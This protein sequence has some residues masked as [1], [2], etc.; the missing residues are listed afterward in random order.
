MRKWT[1]LTIGSVGFTACLLTFVA[2]AKEQTAIRLL[3]GALIQAPSIMFDTQTKAWL[4]THPTINVAYLDSPLQP[5]HLGVD[6]DN[7]EGVTANY[8]SIIKQSTGLTFNFIRYTTRSAAN[9]ALEAGDVDMIELHEGSEQLGNAQAQSHPYL[10]N[11]KVLVRRIAETLNPSDSLKGQR[12]AFVG[13]DSTA[14][15]LHKQFPQADLK[16]YSNHLNALSRLVHNEADAFYSDSVTAEY[17]IRELYANEAYIS[18]TDLQ[19]PANYSFAISNR[20]P[21]LLEV[22]NATIDA[23]TTDDMITI[24]TYWGLGRHF[25]VSPSPLNLT[26]AEARWISN[27]PTIKVVVAGTYAPLTFFDARNHLQGLGADFLKYI[28]KRTGI[29]ME[30]IRNDDGSSQLLALANHQANLAA[31]INIGSVEMDA[32]QLTRPYLTSPFVIITRSADDDI[33]NL[34]AFNGKRLAIPFKHPMWYWIGQNYPKIQ[35]VQV[36]NAMSGVEQLSDG[37]VDGSVHTEFGA[38]YFIKHHF[39]KYL[40]IAMVVGPE[41][42]KLAMAVSNEDL[43]LKSIINKVLLE[44]TP[45]EFKTLSD[46][47][48]NHSAPAVANSWSTYKSTVYNTVVI[49]VVLVLLFIIWNYYLHKQIRLRQRVER[50]LGDQLE[51]TR[52]LIEE[53]PVAVYVRDK[54][55]RLIHCNQTYIEF[56]QTSREALM[57]TTLLQRSLS[58]PVQDQQFQNIYLKVMEHGT[59]TFADIDTY[60]KGK[61]YRIYHWTIPLRDSL[62]EVIG[63][64]GGWLDITERQELLAELSQAK[65]IAD[66]ASRSKSIFLASMSHEIRTPISALVGLL[67]LLRIRAGSPKQLEDNLNIAHQSAQSLLSLTGDILDLAKIEAGGMTP[68]PRPTDLRELM[69]T[70]HKLFDANA[71]K[72]GLAY[73]LAITVSNE[74]VIVDAL[75]LNQITTNLLSN[76]IKFTKHG[77]IELVLEQLP[78]ELENGWKRFQISVTDSGTGLTQEQKKSIFEPFVQIPNNADVRTGTGLGLSICIHLAKLLN[79]SLNVESLLGKGSCFTLEFDAEPT[80]AGLVNNLPLAKANSGR[81]LRVLVVEDHAPNRLLLCQQLEYLGHRAVSCDD[82]ATG[83]TLWEETDLP[84]DLTITDCNMPL[85]SGYELTRKIR[86]IEQYH[87]QRP[88]PIMGLTANAQSKI[89]EECLEAGMTHCLFKPIGVE[90]LTDVLSKITQTLDLHSAA[91]GASGGELQK[92]RVLNPE[93]Y[94]ALVDELVRTQREDATRLTQCL[95]AND[96]P[97]LARLAHKIKGSAQLTEAFTL[98]QACDRLEGYALNGEVPDCLKQ[99]EVMLKV[100]DEL[101]QKLLA[102]L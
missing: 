47:W 80:E 52:T 45:E 58:T 40:K 21:L 75:I 20:K 56:L 67:E 98:L 93:A 68:L 30:I 74:H 53:V 62:G 34:G 42:A 13:D 25:V 10:L 4:D 100:M 96:L 50:K 17:K 51:F 49:A 69:N 16:R 57:G 14:A 1:C 32:N 61:E 55:T 71:R 3:D 91:A 85:M 87:G 27:H 19:T 72:K 59:S 63:I 101:E 70:A 77:S 41:P 38:D 11:K 26:E 78:I 2:L 64:I 12:L 79:A 102:D 88:H 90:A 89:A 95:Q 18:A 29:Q 43:P 82:G 39:N 15:Q 76:A 86:A 83:L 48:R 22:I 92:L 7:F 37:D 66:E 60:I 97:A 46:R 8:L 6:P 84:F 35:R 81:S 28:E 99:I 31:A 44:I 54:D 65:E 36:A 23:I 24:A 94:G 73:S 9:T 5:L 33:V